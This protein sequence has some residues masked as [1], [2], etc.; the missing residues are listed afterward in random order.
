MCADGGCATRVTAKGGFGLAKIGVGLPAIIAR[1]QP[2]RSSLEQMRVNVRAP[3]MASGAF[4]AG[5]PESEWA[6]CRAGMFSG[7]SQG[8]IATTRHPPFGR[9]RAERD[10]HRPE[11]PFERGGISS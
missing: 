10:R 1:Y 9:E 8:R 2:Q 7:L 4:V 5:V 3:N 6:A 11:N